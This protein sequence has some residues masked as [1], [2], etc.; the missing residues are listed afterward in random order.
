M[1]GRFRMLPVRLRRGPDPRP[2][3][4]GNQRLV[5]GAGILIVLLLVLIVTLVAVRLTGPHR[6]FPIHGSG[7]GTTGQH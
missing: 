3:L 7:R 1:R 5:R 2:P 6:R 4:T